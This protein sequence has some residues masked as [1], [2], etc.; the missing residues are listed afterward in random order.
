MTVKFFEVTGNGWNKPVYYAG[1]TV[2]AVKQ[3]AYA[4]SNSQFIV[5]CREIP[6]E[7]IPVSEKFIRTANLEYKDAHWVANLR[8]PDI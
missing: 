5:H 3:E 1:Y 4:D 7:E 6:L 2:E 8:S